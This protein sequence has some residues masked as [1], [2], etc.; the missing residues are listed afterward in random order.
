MEFCVVYGCILCIIFNLFQILFYKKTDNNEY[1][2]LI[3]N[4][5]FIED[6]QL[7]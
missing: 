7:Y 2:S 3:I 4:G 6:T 5:F 1:I